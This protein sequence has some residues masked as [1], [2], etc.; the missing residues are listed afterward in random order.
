MSSKAK[1]NRVLQIWD[2][3]PV[4]YKTHLASAFHTFL[5][6]FILSLA[7]SAVITGDVQFE[8]SAIMAALL[9]AVRA[10]VKAVSLAFFSRTLPDPKN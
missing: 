7:G 6:D 8:S 3:V 1:R 5:S 9:I 2:G 10:G 4:T